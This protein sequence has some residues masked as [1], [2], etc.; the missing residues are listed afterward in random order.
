M[1][2]QRILFLSVALLLTPFLARADFIAP[3]SSAPTFENQQNLTLSI[4]NLASSSEIQDGGSYVIEG[5]ASTSFSYV[6]GH[7]PLWPNRNAS[8]EVNDELFDETLNQNKLYLELWSGEPFTS[9]AHMIQNWD[10]TNAPTGQISVTLP[11]AGPYFF[12]T[13]LPDA[14]YQDPQAA[15]PNDTDWEIDCAP[16]YTLNQMRGYFNSS[17]TSDEPFP[18]APDAFGGI[19]FTLSPA[20]T[21]TSQEASNVLFIPGIEGSR[22]YMRNS[23]GIEEA[24]WEPS[25]L[26]TLSKLT[27]AADGTSEHQIYTRDI[28]DYLYGIPELG[29]VYGPFEKFM[30]SLVTNRMI[31]R[32]QAY[33]YD[34]RY[35]VQDIVSNGTLVGASTGALSRV[36]LQDIVQSMA[37]SSPTG[38]V[39]IIAHSNGGLLAKAL[40][41]DLQK[42]GKINLLDKMILIG[43]PQLGTPT[44]IGA[45]LN[46]D[47]QTDGIGGL[48]MYGGTVRTVAATMPGMYG[49]L[50]QLNTSHLLPVLS[51]RFPYILSIIYMKSIS[52]LVFRHLNNL[53]ILLLT[54]EI[55]EQ[56]FRLMTCIRHSLSQ[57]QFSKKK[58]V[59]TLFLILGHHLVELPSPLSVAG[60]T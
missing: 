30:D 15:C 55:F 18:Y 56:I 7:S 21:P 51:F 37:S 24:L 49:L 58:L 40:A 47:G 13:Y 54:V 35:D 10:I 43:S 22:L 11:S 46:G 6:I 1:T 59:C 42:K 36:Y 60:E 19:A 26:N 52:V 57:I 14:F 32:W 8:D 39:T 3:P 20:T 4:Q 48:V 45:L 50:P 28:V 34:W 27:L 12:V 5:T 29:D 17:L 33:P 23:L 44:T 53:K 38:K 41:I 9:E 16:S 31:K 25:I 2:N